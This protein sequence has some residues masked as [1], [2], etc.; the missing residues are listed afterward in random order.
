MDFKKLADQAKKTLDERG[1]TERLKQD[2][3]RLRDIATGPGS[4]QDK[5]RAAGEALKQ[6]GQPSG[7]SSQDPPVT[8]NP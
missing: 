8:P 3:E 7:Q 1:G 2:A 6:P 4:A 5:A